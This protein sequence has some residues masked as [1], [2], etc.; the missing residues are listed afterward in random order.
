MEWHFKSNEGKF[1]STYK[2]ISFN[3][4]K[5]SFKNKGKIKTCSDKKK[6]ERKSLSAGTTINVKDVVQIEEKW[7]HRETWT[8]RE[9]RVPEIVSM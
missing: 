5:I 4:M 7:N 2:P 6:S 8:V 3:R 1:L 9:G